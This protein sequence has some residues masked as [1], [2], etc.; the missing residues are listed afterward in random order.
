MQQ[1]N[2]RITFCALMLTCTMLFTVNAHSATVKVN[3]GKKSGSTINGVLQRLNPEG[4]NTII[5]S[6]TCN[7]NV[8]IQGL[9]RLTLQA[10]NNG[11]VIND[12][13][14][15][16]NPTITIVDSQRVLIQ[17]FTIN[18]GS[19]GVLCT[20][21]SLCRFSQNTV[22][23]AADDGV[24]ISRSRSDFDRDVLQNNGLRGLVVREQGTAVVPGV[25]IQG[26]ADA[27]AEALDGSFLYAFQSTFQNNAFGIRAENS[28][29]RIEL[30]TISGN[31]LDG[32]QLQEESTARLVVLL[33]PNTITGNGF[34]GVSV[35]DLSFAAFD[36][37]NS[38]T[39]NLMP[40][41]VV[42]NPQFSAT[43][44]ANTNIGGGTTNCVE[45]AN[46]AAR[47]P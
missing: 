39:G 12:T 38:I 45:P 16:N 20:D 46:A 34:Q 9:D 35:N 25:T 5:V 40:P 14:G 42:C 7:E 1:I 28:A 37:G 17:G 36:P 3:C 22:Q 33:G 29:L 10:G 15:G 43:R 2:G 8:L 13:S 24:Q 32:V 27:G 18:G 26:N 4:P 21:Y 19:P 41:D 44:G 31:T 23:G 6:G 30:S 47:K 11:A